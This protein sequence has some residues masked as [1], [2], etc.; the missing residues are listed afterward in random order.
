MCRI[1]W[2]LSPLASC[3]SLSSCLYLLWCYCPLCWHF[4]LHL[5]TLCPRRSTPYRS[6]HLLIFIATTASVGLLNLLTVLKESSDYVLDV[7]RCYSG[8]GLSP[9]AGLRQAPFHLFLNHHDS[10]LQ[11]WYSLCQ[12]CFHFSS[13]TLYTV[14]LGSHRVLAC[15]IQIRARCLPPS[16][17]Y[18]HRYQ[19]VTYHSIPH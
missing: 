19:Q 7:S 8:L 13:S 2:A 4:A 16:L 17:P 1:S 14:C 18:S 10:L 9:L 11:L 6:S 5:S 12:L 15:L 3:W